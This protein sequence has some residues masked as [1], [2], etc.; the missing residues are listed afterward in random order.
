[1]WP[2][3]G[4]PRTRCSVHTWWIWMNCQTLNTWDKWH[5]CKTSKPTSIQ[6][7]QVL[8]PTPPTPELASA[9][10]HLI[11]TLGYLKLQ[12]AFIAGWVLWKQM[13]TWSLRCSSETK[14][15]EGKE[16][17]LG[18]GR[19]WRGLSQTRGKSWS[20]YLPSR[21]PA[22]HQNYWAS[23][24]R[25]GLLDCH[26]NCKK[27]VILARLLS[28]AEAD[29]EG[30][31][32]CKPCAVPKAGWQV[33]PWRVIWVAHLWSTTGFCIYLHLCLTVILGDEYVIIP[34]S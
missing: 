3:A 27:G 20:E 12:K 15:Q 28:T 18:R 23:V 17:G 29:P 24:T 6:S 34:I 1:M 4:C 10:C 2:P 7:L 19:G 13:P 30:I 21:C 32:G 8:F 14:T 25:C 31:G 16:A 22:L 33:L 11:K 5:I 26:G 9:H